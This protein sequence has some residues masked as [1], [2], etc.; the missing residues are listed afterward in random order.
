[1]KTRICEII[2]GYNVHKNEVDHMSIRMFLI[3]NAGTTCR[4]QRIYKWIKISNM[5]IAFDPFLYI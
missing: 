5:I 4:K 3:M 2:T 1:M